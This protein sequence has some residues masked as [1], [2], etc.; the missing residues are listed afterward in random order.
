MLLAL[1]MFPNWELTRRI[2]NFWRHRTPKKCN[3]DHRISA[4]VIIMFFL[5]LATKKSPIA[6]CFWGV[7][8]RESQLWTAL[9]SRKRTCLLYSDQATG[10][11]FTKPLREIYALRSVMLQKQLS[12]HWPSR[13]RAIRGLPLMTS[14]K[15]SDFLTPPSPCPQI[16]AT[17][18]TKVA[19]YDCFWRYPS[20]PP[21]SVRTS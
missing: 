11:S 19:Y 1:R 18:L 17:S 6:S 9:R 20:G 21:P 3:I 15:I 13:E 16:N 12:Q 4:V 2:K 8:R 10:A 14:A 7:R 5:T